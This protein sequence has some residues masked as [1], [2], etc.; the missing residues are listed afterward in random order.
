MVFA[1]SFSHNLI[2]FENKDIFLGIVSSSLYQ[3]MLTQSRISGKFGPKYFITPTL[4]WTHFGGIWA[5]NNPRENKQVTFSNDTV[6]Y[7]LKQVIWS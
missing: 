5:K 6:L 7:G 1:D 4:K 3:A 2:I